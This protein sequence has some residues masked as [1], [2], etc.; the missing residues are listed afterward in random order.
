M[1]GVD[2]RTRSYLIGL[3]EPID[4]LRLHEFE[5][6]SKKCF[7]CGT[8]FSEASGAYESYPKKKSMGI[9]CM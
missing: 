8:E 4:G 3:K 2:E 1:F 9:F 7:I 5:Q 6:V